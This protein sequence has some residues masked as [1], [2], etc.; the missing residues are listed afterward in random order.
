MSQTL[1]PLVSIVMPAFRAEQTIARAVQSV[2][3]Q[4][5][6][7]WELLIVADDGTDYQPVLADRGLADPRLRFFS[8]G[9]MKAG[10]APAR[11]VGLDAARGRYVALLDAD[12][13]FAPE[14]LARALKALASH[15][16]VSTALQVTDAALA[17][18]R[19]V[20]V[21]PDRALS[22]ADY[23]FVNLSMDSMLVYDRLAADPRYDESFERLTDIAFLMRLFKTID[24]VLHLGAPLH[25]YTKQP[26]SMSSGPGAGALTIA[27]KKRLLADL[28]AG[29]YS[30]AA[31][32]TAEGLAAFYD[33]SLVAEESFEA[34]LEQNPALLFEDHLEPLLGIH[35]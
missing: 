18:L 17:P 29:A 11:N 8:S 22:P 25:T 21:G 5:H 9:G 16:L 24:H 15:P 12:D 31:P 34:A 28:R 32:D 3:A 33:R 2:F 20:G 10:S 27:T 19:T 23:K 1:D 35:D 30:F 26:L 13:L 7:E 14:K 6:G 4:T